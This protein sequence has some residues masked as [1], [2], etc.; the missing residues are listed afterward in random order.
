MRNYIIELPS[1]EEMILGFVTSDIGRRGCIGWMMGGFDLSGDMFTIWINESGE[2]KTEVFEDECYSVMQ[3][4]DASIMN[5]EFRLR[6][7]CEICKEGQ[8]GGGGLDRTYLFKIAT[9]GYTY[10]IRAEVSRNECRF[11]IFCYVNVVM[12]EYLDVIYA[13]EFHEYLTDIKIF[14]TDKGFVIAGFEYDS[15]IDGTELL[16][17]NITKADIICAAQYNDVEQFFSY[18]EENGDWHIIKAGTPEFRENFNSFIG[19]KEDYKGCT[20]KTMNALKRSV[21][22]EVQ[23]DG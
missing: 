1:E 16:Y 21:G 6:K 20:E 5:S 4:L 18:L 11:Y 3:Y 13:Q 8:I 19:C 10:F 22:V 12:K 9:H 14:R 17:L 2:Y 23:D 15:E 7:F